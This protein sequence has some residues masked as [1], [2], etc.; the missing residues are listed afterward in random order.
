VQLGS[1]RVGPDLADVGARLGNADWQL[2]HLYAP[3]SV[4]KNSAMP[5]FRFLFETKKIGDA[6]SP[7]ALNLPK[8]FAPPA[9]YEVVPTPEAKHLAAYL[10]SLRADAPLYE[11]PF[12][13]TQISTNAPAK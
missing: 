3:Q 5:P 8:E 9:G 7:D 6:S 12:T 11:A 4:V 10:L 2:L 13:P 1:Q